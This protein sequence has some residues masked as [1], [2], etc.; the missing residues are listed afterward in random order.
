[1]AA[2][3][4]DTSAYLTDFQDFLTGYL[5][6]QSGNINGHFYSPWDVLSMVFFCTHGAE[7]P[8][9]RGAIRK[10]VDTHRN[11]EETFYFRKL[12]IDYERITDRL[13]FNMG[14]ITLE[15]FVTACNQFVHA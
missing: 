2:C 9:I 3:C 7:S 8:C 12:I 4:T 5:R 10:K 11:L 15:A 13:L 6:V 14:S 1:M